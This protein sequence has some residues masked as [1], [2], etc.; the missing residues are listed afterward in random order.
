MF[1]KTSETTIPVNLIID[2]GSKNLK[3][4][5]YNIED[6]KVR[7]Q[8]YYQVKH[9]VNFSFVKG[10]DS[11][12]LLNI[13]VEV[14]EVFVKK[15]NFDLRQMHVSIADELVMVKRKKVSFSLA[16]DPISVELGEVKNLIHKS[17]WKI[18][19]EVKTNHQEENPESHIKLLTSFINNVKLD[20]VDTHNPVG[21]TGRHI[22][23]D[24]VN[25]YV[26]PEIYTL[27]LEVF[28]SLDISLSSVLVNMFSFT[29]L[30][31]PEKLLVIDLGAKVTNLCLI[32]E[33]HF[34][35]IRSLDFGVN[36]IVDE[37][38]KSLKIGFEE[39]EGLLID[40]CQNNFNKIDFYSFRKAVLKG[41]QKLLKQMNISNLEFDT[42]KLVGGGSHIP[43]F[44]ELMLQKDDKVS[45]SQLEYQDFQ[46]QNPD[47][48]FP[49]LSALNC[50]NLAHF[51]S[52]KSQSPSL[53]QV[54]NQVIKLMQI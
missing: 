33:K 41:A 13:I 54:L 51:V 50:L 18:T 47:Y 32:Q 28:N 37:I 6:S 19:N 10:F 35:Y 21:Q 7:I 23:F 22:Q 2:I 36:I 5:V 42:I 16:D 12:K 29:N 3:F 17:Q 30:E 43:E 31:T 14:L 4:F 46:L 44:T 24:F 39:A 25:A 11:K 15:F 8:Y 40:Y 26:N 53:N 9:G 48:D 52:N 1:F 45:I 49:D 20:G 34:E 27:F 38:S